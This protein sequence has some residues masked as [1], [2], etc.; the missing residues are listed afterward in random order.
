MKRTL[1]L[2]YLSLC[3]RLNFL[4]ILILT[5]YE[6]KLLNLTS[7][8]YKIDVFLGERELCDLFESKNSNF[9]IQLNLNSKEAVIYVYNLE[10]W[11]CEQGEAIFNE[12]WR[13][14]KLRLLCSKDCRNVLK[15]CQKE[16]C[17]E[18]KPFKIWWWCLCI[19]KSIKNNF[20]LCLWC[21]QY[22]HICRFGKYCKYCCG[23]RDSWKVIVIKMVKIN[24]LC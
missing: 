16:N 2:K 8:T 11:A 20:L 18:M 23:R 1:S 5:F 7:L 14:F 21:F 3:W 22:Y 19:V 9:E 15:L 17:N 10:D 13:N 12:P 4:T 24:T 6:A